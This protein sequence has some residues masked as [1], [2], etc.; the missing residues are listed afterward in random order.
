MNSLIT[1]VIEDKNGTKVGIYTYCDKSHIISAN[2]MPQDSP[3]GG[4]IQSKS[5]QIV[6]AWEDNLYRGT[7]LLQVLNRWMLNPIANGRYYTR[8]NDKGIDHQY[9][10]MNYNA[11]FIVIVR[12]TNNMPIA[13]LGIKP[14]GENVNY[15]VDADFRG[16]K[17]MELHNNL[18]FGYVLKHGIVANGLKTIYTRTHK[19]NI[20]SNKHQLRWGYK[21]SGVIDRDG[22]EYNRY[23]ET[24]DDRIKLIEKLA[25]DNGVT[26]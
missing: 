18:V 17:S 26:I 10:I 15:W 3:I 20:A 23:E 8:D 16:V 22:V 4:I 7:G 12:R 21:L 11:D 19:D 5:N 1:N 14:D 9:S 24:I 6:L 2:E 25:I 13:C